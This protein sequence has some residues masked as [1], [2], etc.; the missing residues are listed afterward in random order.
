MEHAQ[1]LFQVRRT[2]LQMLRDRGYLVSEAELNTTVEQFS[3][4][5]GLESGDF[6]LY[7]SIR[8]TTHC[9]LKAFRLNLTQKQEG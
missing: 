3:E 9:I 1:R 4:Q 7:T 6:K 2:S 5:F 8:Q